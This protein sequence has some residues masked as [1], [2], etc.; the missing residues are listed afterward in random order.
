MN[1]PAAEDER[2]YFAHSATLR[3][4]GKSLPF[5]AIE[6]A[7]GVPPSHTHVTGERRRRSS[8]AFSDDAWHYAAPVAED[9]ELTEHLRCLWR[10]VEP[11]VAYLLALNANVDV[12]CGYRSNN[13]SGGF[14][15]EP[16]ALQIFTALN[17]PFGV[18]VI[19]ESWLEERPSKPTEH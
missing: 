12:F 2:S 18:S 7:L 16:D 17:V 9:A 19:V 14:A 15:V 6:E 4:H 5:K 11:A 13:N 1:I 10:T 8:R 3:I